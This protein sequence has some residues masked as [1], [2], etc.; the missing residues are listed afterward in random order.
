M[1]ITLNPEMERLVDERLASGKYASAGEVVQDALRVLSLEEEAHQERR[2]S[3]R[4]EITA[5]I[6]QIERGECRRYDSARALAD[7]IKKERRRIL[8]ARK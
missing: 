1:E 6:A 4:R 5:A 3:L 7:D 8:A 2:A